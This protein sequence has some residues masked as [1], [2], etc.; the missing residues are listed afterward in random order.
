MHFAEL[1]NP[2]FRAKRQHTRT[3]GVIPRGSVRA[4]LKFGRG[5]TGFIEGAKDIGFRIVSVR[6]A[7]A[8]GP[9][10]RNHGALADPSGNECLIAGRGAGVLRAHFEQRDAIETPV[11]IAARGG[12]EIRQ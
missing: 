2:A 3:P 11:G 10:T 12:D 7:R 8:A 6:R 5:R 9:V 4:Q 1:G